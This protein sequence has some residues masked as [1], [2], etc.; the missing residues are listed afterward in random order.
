MT[1]EIKMEEV[2]AVP[3]ANE[4]IQISQISQIP[5]VNESVQVPEPES[6]PDRVY[7]VEE[8]EG[9]PFIKWAKVFCYKNQWRVTHVLGD[10]EDCLA[11][12]ALCYVICCKNY[13][14]S[15]NSAK[16]FMFMYKLWVEAEFNTMSTNE[17]KERLMKERLPKSEASVESEA[18][19]V[20][21]LTEGSSELKSVL[22][23]FLNAP[24]ELMQILRQ[25]ANS[26]HPKQFWKIALKAAGVSSSRS[27]VLAKEL[28]DLLKE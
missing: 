21:K 24:Q 28:Q 16:Q 14:A 7:I 23:L 2:K 19:L 25:E 5:V 10:Y 8:W 3:A 18:Q 22:R 4:A 15:V 17:S 11:Y 1:G 20:V 13:G 26:C 6:K 12:C 27:A 9:S